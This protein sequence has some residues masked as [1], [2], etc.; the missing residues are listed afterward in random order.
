MAFVIAFGFKGNSLLPCSLDGAASVTSLEVSRKHIDCFF[1]C[2][3]PH[4][5]G[6]PQKFTGL[7]N[8][9]YD[10]AFQIPR[11]FMPR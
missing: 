9:A 4:L 5:C 1:F 2:W 6:A 3:N 8:A 7:N 11:K 10:L